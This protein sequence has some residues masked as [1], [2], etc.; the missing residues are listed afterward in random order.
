MEGFPGADGD[1]G[2]PGVLG[3]KGV[4]GFPGVPGVKG[5]KVVLKNSLKPGEDQH[6][7]SPYDIA[8]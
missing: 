4:I 5:N 2:P 3:P 6:L 8:G 1:V 7:I